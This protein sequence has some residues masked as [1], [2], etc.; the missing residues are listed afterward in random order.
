MNES[1]MNNLHWLFMKASL[2]AKQRLMK[3]S[4]E[5]DLTVMQV[6]TLFLLDPGVAVPMHSIS[7][8]LSCDPSNVTGIVDRLVAGSY[9]ERQENPND[10][11]VKV[12]RLT[13]KGTAF[14][15]LLMKR[16]EKDNIPDLSQ[17]SESENK[18]LLKLLTKI[19][20]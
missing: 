16:L 1:S 19:L 3:I 5:Y 7:G 10:R 11:R 13:E 15:D 17:L 4:E 12:I 9:I 18:S 8:L 20:G 2:K 14:R 6:Y